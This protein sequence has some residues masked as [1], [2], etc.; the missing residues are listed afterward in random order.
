MYG[1]QRAHSRLQD[2]V[3]NALVLELEREA[4]LEHRKLTNRTYK[5]SLISSSKCFLRF[6]VSCYVAAK[7]Q[8]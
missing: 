2:S 8:F 3:T 4:A 6:T 1:N 5:V 7:S